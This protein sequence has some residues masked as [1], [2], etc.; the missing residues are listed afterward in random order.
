MATYRGIGVNFGISSSLANITGAFQSRN[1]TFRAEMD[2]IKNGGGDTM[3]K[4]YYD[5]SEEASFTYVATGTSGGAVTVTKPTIGALMTIE[6]TTYPA[7]AATN[8]LV[9]EVSTDGSN[10][11]AV[12][13]TLKLTKYPNITS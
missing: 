8:W 9:D 4:V 5:Q 3:A 13:V 6:D 11:A 10:T 7:I 12:R 2:T 1:H